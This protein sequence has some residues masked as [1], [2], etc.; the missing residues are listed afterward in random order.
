M[1]E[2][3]AVE[4]V[5]YEDLVFVTRFGVR[6]GEDVGALECLVAEAE[7]VVDDEDG[8]GGLGGASGICGWSVGWIWRRGH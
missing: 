8:G 2:R 3:L 1:R 7:N 5:R 6:V 4:E